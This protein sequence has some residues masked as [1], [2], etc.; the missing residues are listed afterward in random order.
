MAVGLIE[1]AG[2]VAGLYATVTDDTRGRR[3]LRSDGSVFTLESLGCYHLHDVV[4]HLHDVRA[5]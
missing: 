2:D 1:A 4:H 5:G 3:G